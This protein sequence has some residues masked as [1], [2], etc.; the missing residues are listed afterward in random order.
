LNIN[1]G[2]NITVERCDF[3]QISEQTSTC[4]GLFVRGCGFDRLL[5]QYQATNN[6]IEIS[7][8][9]YKYADN[10]TPNTIV[11]H[12]VIIGKGYNTN[13]KAAGTVFTNSIFYNTNFNAGNNTGCV[14]TNNL[15]Y[16]ITVTAFTLP[17]SGSTGSNNSAALDPLFIGGTTGDPGWNNIFDYNWRLPLTSPGHNTASDG[18]DLGVYG[19]VLAVNQMGLI[20]AIPQVNEINIGNAAVPQN[21]T[22]NV[23]F[24]ARKQN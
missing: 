1:H 23:T 11:N 18:A 4:N 5:N 20:P 16:N 9:V 6:P 7:N 10:L 14:F 12:C 2:R 19:G 17:L 15:V 22:L 21:G 3:Y 24:K 8:C 13:W